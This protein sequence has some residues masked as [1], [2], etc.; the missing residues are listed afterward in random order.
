[1]QADA[2]SHLVPNGAAFA[3]E[4]RIRYALTH[5]ARLLERYDLL[6][7]EVLPAGGIPAPR[8]LRERTARAGIAY[9]LLA[10]DGDQVVGGI[11][12]TVRDAGNRHV[13]LPEEEDTPSR[14]LGCHPLLARRFVWANHLCIDPRHRG[15]T[16]LRELARHLGALARLFHAD[17]IGLMCKLDMV[18]T[19]QATCFRYFGVRGQRVDLD[20]ELPQRYR[21]TGAIFL[22]FPTLGAFAS[23]GA[24]LRIQEHCERHA[25][26]L[27]YAQPRPA[28]AMHLP[29]LARRGIGG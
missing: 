25:L 11:C 7:R 14:L 22:I 10:L 9:P 16:I 2:H 28:P 5:D 13:L 15:H 21:D 1:M 4:V 12:A 26:A 24:V 29:G 6:A 19:I 23:E 27:P 3:P 17:A 8:G 18:R 20:F